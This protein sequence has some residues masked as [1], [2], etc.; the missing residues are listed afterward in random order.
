VPDLSPYAGPVSSA[1]PAE[2][3]RVEVPG[4]LLR[5][6]RSTDTADLLAAFADEEIARWNPGP[7]DPESVAEFMAGRNDWSTSRH[8]SWA[9]ADPSDRLIG[10]VSLHKIDLEQADA[11]MGYWIAP[12][13]RRQGQ[14]ARAVV[15]A[16][17]FAFDRLGL[18]RVY[19]YHAVENLGS[20]GV[21]RAAGFLHEA[22]SGSRSGTPTAPI[23][24]ST[25]TG[26]SAATSTPTAARSRVGTGRPAS[27]REH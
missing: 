6:F 10:S 13:A 9:V 23:T 8:A 24:T 19:L 11:E 2:P 1:A 3:V 17:R 25:C 18:H 20:C 21:A 5:E 26:C 16:S 22:R 4:L 27:R 15:A 14:A 7:A 12:W